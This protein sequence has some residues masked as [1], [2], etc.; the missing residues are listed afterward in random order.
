MVL[1]VLTYAFGEAIMK[2]SKIITYLYNIQTIHVLMHW[3]PL[4][5]GN[6]TH[7]KI[8]IFIIVNSVNS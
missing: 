8:V 6:K 4:E 1:V 7:K 5:N 2:T 3:N